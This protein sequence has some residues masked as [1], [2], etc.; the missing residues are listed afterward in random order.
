MLEEHWAGFKEQNKRMSSR[1]SSSTLCWPPS[2]LQA[3]LEQVLGME[4]RAKLVS[5]WRRPILARST[6]AA[7]RNGSAVMLGRKPL[8]QEA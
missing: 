3:L 8:K 6:T 2:G 1:P 7:S 4:T 5:Y